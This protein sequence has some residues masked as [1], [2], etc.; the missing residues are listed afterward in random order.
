M[1]IDIHV[2]AYRIPVPF[3]CKFCSAEELIRNMDANGIDK[4]IVLPIVSP[5]IYLPQA[6]EDI[7]EM[8]EQYPD[9]LYPFCNID[10]RCLSNSATAKLE[11][12]LQ[13][14]KNLGC[15]GVGEVMP[16]MH[17]MDPKVQNLF[18]AAEVVDMPVIYD[19][20]SV[21]TEDFG[22]YDDIGH[23]GL[24]YTLARFPKLKILGHGPV[25]WSEIAPLETPASR[26]P[27]FNI[28]NDAQI[29]FHFNQSPVSVEGVIPKLFRLFPNLFGDL[30][31]MFG[32]NAIARDEIYGPKFLTE[33][34]DRL[35]NGS[36][37][38]FD[39]AEIPLIPL[40]KKYLTEGKITKEVYDKIMYKN[41]IRLFNL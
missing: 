23:P 39:E 24:E 1:I 22:L 35:C 11:V 10:P 27:I 20:S 31:D 33:F 6:N 2:H 16:N 37:I 19:G 14:Y 15:R 21:T 41:A 32:Y 8:V 30:S 18:R 3:V 9:R 7:L 25:F 29:E 38:C 26:K 13:Y 12:I 28:N 34:Q 4:A 36:D 5:E 40:M 17:I